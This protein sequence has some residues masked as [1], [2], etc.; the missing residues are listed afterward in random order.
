MAEAASAEELI[1]QAITTAWSTGNFT[2][3][4]PLPN[5]DGRSAA[6]RAARS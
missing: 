2:H 1:G 4:F 6:V 5:S 3:R